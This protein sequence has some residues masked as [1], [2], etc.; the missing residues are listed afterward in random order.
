[1]HHE[2]IK[3]HLRKRGISLKKLA[4]ELEINASTISIIIRRHRV[5]ER[6]ERA[7]A[8]KLDMPLHEVFPDRYTTPAA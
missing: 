7:I 4:D 6:V 5:S 1:M 3:A 8:L 2:D